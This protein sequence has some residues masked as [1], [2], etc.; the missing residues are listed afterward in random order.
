M[1]LIQLGYTNNND[2]FV[3]CKDENQAKNKVEFLYLKEC[4]K[5]PL[6]PSAVFFRR[7]YKEDRVWQ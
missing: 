7:F 5:L 6:I 3:F 1:S 2:G 4:E